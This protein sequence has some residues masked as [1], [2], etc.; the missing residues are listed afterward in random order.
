MSKYWSIDEFREVVKG[1]KTIREVLQHFGL[2]KNQGYYNREFHKTVDEFHIDISHIVENVKTQ[3]FRKRIP[4]DELFVKGDQ[5]NTQSLKKRLIKEGLAKDEC[6]ECGQLPL[7]N[8]KPLVLQLDHINGD[9][10]DNRIENLRILC[11]HCHSQTETWSGRNAQEK[12]IHKHACS[13]CGGPKKNTKSDKC[14]KCENE[15]RK[16]NTKIEWPSVE[17]V[18]QMTKQLGFVATG[19]SL[20]VSDNAVRKFLKRSGKG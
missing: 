18:S 16:E 15:A 19:K 20:G 13:V 6:S 11:P 8:N 9:N 7:W 3:S 12:H 10:T 17:T 5:R 4:L 2:P 14:V 1:S